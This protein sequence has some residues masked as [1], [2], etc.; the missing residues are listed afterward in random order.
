MSR[1]YPAQCSKTQHPSEIAL[2][3]QIGQKK[4]VQHAARIILHFSNVLSFVLHG[5]LAICAED[6]SDPVLAVAY[7]D[8]LENHACLVP[9]GVTGKQCVQNHV[10][11]S[12]GAPVTDDAL[13]RAIVI[14]SKVGQGQ[15]ALHV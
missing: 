13:E 11:Q 4:V 10:P 3:R 8:R 5:K 6:V 7:M 9:Q 14:V 12:D 15:T 2:A 1:G